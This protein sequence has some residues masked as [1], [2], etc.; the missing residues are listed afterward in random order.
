MGL[1]ESYRQQQRADER[2]ES[3]DRRAA[4]HRQRFTELAKAGDSTTIRAI[5][6]EFDKRMQSDAMFSLIV[7]AAKDECKFAD[8]VHD[9]IADLAYKKAQAEAYEN[10][11]RSIGR[12]LNLSALG[13]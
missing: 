8:L 3:L 4:H 7:A 12:T 11:Q 10:E 5:N 13:G 1:I 2:S 9:I 6:N